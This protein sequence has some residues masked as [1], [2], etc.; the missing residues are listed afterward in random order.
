MMRFDDD[1]RMCGPGMNFD[2]A[3]ASG[4]ERIVAV[5]HHA[6]QKVCAT[7]LQTSLVKQLVASPDFD[8]DAVMSILQR[9][10]AISYSAADAVAEMQQLVLEHMD[11]APPVAQRRIA[12]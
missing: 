3:T 7:V 9:I 11:L 2:V 10:T 4:I 8:R 6:Q 5:S 1:R 12:A